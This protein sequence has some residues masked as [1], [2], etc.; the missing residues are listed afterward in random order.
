MSFVPSSR[1]LRLPSLLFLHKNKKK[2][3][4]RRRLMRPHICEFLIEWTYLNCSLPWTRWLNKTEKITFCHRFFLCFNCCHFFFLFF[5]CNL[6]F[7]QK[8]Y[9]NL[10]RLFIYLVFIFH[11]R[12]G[13][14]KGRRKEEGERRGGGGNVANFFFIFAYT[15]LSIEKNVSR[16]QFK[17]HIVKQFNRKF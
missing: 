16:K 8:K 17:R 4:H 1:S 6:K 5:F 12:G 11:R 13:R 2:K 15:L 7:E 10:V 3:N 9:L 14:R